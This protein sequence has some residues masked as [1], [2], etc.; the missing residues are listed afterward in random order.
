MR[1]QRD[2]SR[3]N[4]SAN[5]SRFLSSRPNTQ[6]GEFLALS[7]CAFPLRFPFALSLCAFPLRFPFALSLCAFPL[8]C[9]LSDLRFVLAR[10]EANLAQLDNERYLFP[11]IVKQVQ[12]SAGSSLQVMPIGTPL[13]D[14]PDDGGGGNG[15][16]GEGASDG[17][18]TGDGNGNGNGDGASGSAGDGASGSAGDGASGDRSSGKPPRVRRAR[19]QFHT[20]RLSSERGIG[21]IQIRKILPP[22][23]TLI[24]R[25][26]EAVSGAAGG[27][28]T[29]KA[30]MVNTIKVTPRRQPSIPQAD[31]QAIPQAI[32]LTSA[33]TQTLSPLATMSAVTASVVASNNQVSNTAPLATMKAVSEK[34]VSAS[35]SERDGS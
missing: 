6:R 13:P 35:E 27:S 17:D 8:R 19:G 29:G 11:F 28:G 15:S 31:S 3:R 25:V 26:N 30:P 1:I 24:V 20:W 32:P 9:A 4:A 23:R 5:L 33:E 12:V 10:A 18:D 34:A 22:Q 21:P 14:N 2:S 16:A 7:L